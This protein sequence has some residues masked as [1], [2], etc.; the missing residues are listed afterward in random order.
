MY[1]PTHPHLHTLAHSSLLL[2]CTAPVAEMQ[3]GLFNTAGWLLSSLDASDVVQ[4]W[5][6][7]NAASVG[8]R[9]YL[10]FSWVDDMMDG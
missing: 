1:N 6:E 7:R 2:R 9:G 5:S 3:L 4:D 8:D 10:Y